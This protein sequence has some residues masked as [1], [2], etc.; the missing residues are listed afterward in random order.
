MKR[1]PDQGA[2]PPEQE[3]G[4]DEERLRVWEKSSPSKFEPGTPYGQNIGT[5]EE[6][7]LHRAIELAEAQSWVVDLG[8]PIGTIAHLDLMPA[9]AKGSRTVP[10]T[11]LAL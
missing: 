6:R 7:V 8:R 4:K 5:A 11:T 10:G 3:Q 2:E 1:R 9:P